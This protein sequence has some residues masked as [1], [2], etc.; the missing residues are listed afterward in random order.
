M[1]TPTKKVFV[2]GIPNAIEYPAKK[3]LAE[4]FDEWYASGSKWMQVHHRSLEMARRY[5]QAL[6][7]TA[8]KYPGNFMIIMTSDA[9]RTRLIEVEVA[10]MVEENV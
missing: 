9:Q 3:P 6:R 8:S 2:E 4:I 10:R 7:A 5:Y 1:T